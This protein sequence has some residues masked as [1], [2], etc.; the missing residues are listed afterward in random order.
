MM[1]G[2]MQRCLY[3]REMVNNTQRTEVTPEDMKIGALAIVVD[4]N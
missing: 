4:R 2:K 1:N 3:S